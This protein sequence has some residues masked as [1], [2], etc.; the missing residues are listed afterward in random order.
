[1]KKAF[2]LYSAA[3]VALVA[4]AD[5]GVLPRGFID[6]LPAG[7]KAGHF[8]LI[9]LLSLLVN[10]AFASP[11]GFTI[12]KRSSLVAVVVFLEELSQAALRH[13]HFEAADLGADFAGI[14]VFA[15]LAALLLSKRGLAS[16]PGFPQGARSAG[17][18]PGFSAGTDE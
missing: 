16:T 5:G 8:L 15:L 10:L 2:L 11:G 4:A 7:D 3:L 17:I 6:R 12:V 9:G 1:M 13:R 18:T 14:V